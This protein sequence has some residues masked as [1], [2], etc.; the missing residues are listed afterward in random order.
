[1]TD[2]RE[3]QILMAA[4][5]ISMVD[6]SREQKRFFQWYPSRSLL[7]AIRAYQ[8]A[9][10]PTAPIWRRLAIERHRLWSIVTGADIPVTSHIG[11]GL[12]L[13][14]PNGVV[15][16]PDAAIGANCI[17]FQQ[18]TIGTI[19]GGYPKIGDYVLIGAGAK[20]LGP[21]TIGQGAKI[22]ANAV[23]VCDV[24]AGCTAIGIPAR[25]TKPENAALTDGLP[26]DGATIVL[27][28]DTEN[29]SRFGE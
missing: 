9:K 19:D 4:R 18:V 20:V 21:V 22:G 10:G 13:P 17:I 1:V 16:A 7:A 23:V 6:W 3:T 15:I 27:D 5:A 2:A 8:N 26:R 24:P 12:M 25:V 29:E 28:N 11:G 14:H